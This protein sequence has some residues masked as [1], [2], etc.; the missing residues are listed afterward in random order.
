MRVRQ[1][2]L[3]VPRALVLAV[4]VILQ[5]GCGGGGDG[6]GGG[7]VTPPPTRTPASV[8]FDAGST[9]SGTV[10]AAVSGTITV[11][12]RTSDN[13]PVP[14]TTVSFT[15]SAGTISSTSAQ[16]D[17]NGRATA[18][19]WTLGT[20]A[21]SQTL[22]ATAGSASAQLVAT[23][24]AAT[25]ATI[26][27][28]TGLPASIRA[29][30]PVTPAPVVRAKD[31]YAN[32]VNRPGTVITATLQSGAGTLGGAQVTTD[33][34]G[35]AT[36]SALTLSGLV[37]AGPRTIAF[38][39]TG[40]PTVA[41]PPV[42]LEAGTTATIT[43]QNVP[44]FARA[45]V[46]IA[47]GVVAR[48]SDAFGNP[49]S[50]PTPV[51]ATLA[52]GS[53]AIAGNAA[54]TNTLGEATFASLA[55]EGL[56]GNRQLRFTADQ[57]SATTGSITLAPGDASQLQVTSQP[58][59]VENTI[60]FPSDVVV[61]VTDRFGN[62][63]ADAGRG[64]AA[65]IA[66]G[67]GVL[68]GTAAQTDAVGVARFA[69]LRLIGSAGPRTLVFTTGGLAP[70]TS[71]AIQLDAGPARFVAFFQQPSG[72]V[73][74]GVPLLQQPALQLAD[75][76]GNVVRRAGA[77]VRATVLDANGELLNDVAITD[78]QG[79]AR[80]EQLTFLSATAFPPPTMRLRFSSGAQ[81]A[82]VT[83]N[84]NIQNAPGSG[85]QSVTYGT[86]AQRL[87]LLDPGAT[88]NLSAVA[89]D[90]LGNPLPQ[91]SMVYSSM[92][93]NTASVRPTGAITGVAGGSSWV[94]AFGS[95]SP[96]I[97]D[98]VYVTVPRDPTGPVVS[99]T[100]IAPIQV[101]A[102]VTAG[103]DIVLDTRS[104]T[105]GAATILVGIPNEMVA[106]INAQ[107]LVGNVVLGV[108]AGLNTLR[109]SLTAPSGL[110]GVVP[111]VRVTL[112]SNAGLGF[113]FNR[114]IVINPL[115][116]YDTNLQNLAARSTGVNIPLVP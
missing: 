18:G 10:G 29:G 91:V 76:S 104:T 31:Q 113:L 89:R 5:S 63:V 40:L 77:P 32:V 95:G 68:T 102:G 14:R 108:D 19:T 25:P 51:T 73:T 97:R 72:T 86:T 33:A 65:A 83:G 28:V 47:P 59:V 41:A 111:I 53:G 43:L 61:R 4:A 71:A 70:V 82:V 79:V 101:R 56:V 49:M 84:L 90:L 3:W 15:T 16:T 6:G 98:S 30:V 116:M 17:D 87:F 103:F 57:V 74:V 54:T 60:P 42:A 2:N 109:I 64:V 26:E 107:G 35:I 22:T 52:Q 66:T 50:R 106:S 88:L 112:T 99:T 21:G 62:G 75:T 45:G 1:S 27:L 37:S 93:A 80:F 44:T 100:Q 96:N 92:N 23:A 46:V 105:V 58:T 38:T 94:R 67:G 114:E 20:T 78:N 39:A 7:G 69:G 34:N 115:E 85:V 9:A 24:A 81:A 13:L 8:T 48:L 11:T 110:S 55:L 36:F 12:V